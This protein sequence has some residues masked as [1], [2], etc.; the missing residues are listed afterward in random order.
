VRTPRL[1]FPDTVSVRVTAAGDRGSSLWLYSRSQIGQFDFGAKE[2]RLRKLIYE[3]GRD[4]PQAGAH[5]GFAVTT[6]AT[7]RS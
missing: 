6:A 3:A 4:L 2:S 7:N 5:D 1:R